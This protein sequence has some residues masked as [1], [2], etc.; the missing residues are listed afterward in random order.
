LVG[1]PADLGGMQ[2]IKRI[3]AAHR[4]RQRSCVTRIY[5]RTG[6]SR[7]SRRAR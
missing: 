5:Q 2:W 6:M 4:R 3:V 7:E 1:Q